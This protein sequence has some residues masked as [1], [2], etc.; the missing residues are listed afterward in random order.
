[1]NLAFQGTINFGGLGTF[2]IESTKHL[3]D[4]IDNIDIFPTIKSAREQQKIYGIYGVVPSNVEI[5]KRS[6]SIYNFFRDTISF[7]NFDIVHVNYAIFGL[8]ALISK[9]LYNTPY[10]YTLHYTLHFTPNPTFWEILCKLHYKIEEDIFV[11]IVAKNANELIVLSNHNK[12]I[13]KVRYGLDATVIYG[14]I[15]IKKF[16]R[17]NDNNTCK[18][19]LTNTLALDKD[20]TLLLFVGRFH[21]YKD[22][23]TLIRA[24]GKVIKRCKKVKLLIIGGGEAYPQVKEEIQKNEVNSHVIILNNISD[25]DLL[26][27]YAGTDIF[28][29]P[30]IGEGFGLV[31]LEA[32]ASGLPIIAAN[33]GASPEVVGDAGLLFEPRNSEDLADKILELINNKELYEK[34]RERGL[35]RV[36]QF[37]WEKAAQE[38]FEIYKKVVEES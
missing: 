37:T 16:S 15:D 1:M 8:A 11:P 20:S 34:L 2:L 7:R 9:K 17:Y 33:A 4:K 25:E 6:N 18:D 31:F 35:E 26:K 23:P 36:K 5:H 28:V 19:Y 10:I 12:K 30:S 22:I 32:M 13:I 24:M 21:E 14:G 3:S 27:Y 29:F 38:Y